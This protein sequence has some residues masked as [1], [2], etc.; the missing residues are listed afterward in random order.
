MEISRIED[1]IVIKNCIDDNIIESYS[2]DK[3]INFSGLTEYLLK[4]NLSKEIELKN[5]IADIQEK[6]QNLV[7]IINQIIESYNSKVREYKKF[8][9][10]LKA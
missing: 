9:D 2:F 10:D 6:E 1:N 4:Q 7:N 5:N 8:L 3:E